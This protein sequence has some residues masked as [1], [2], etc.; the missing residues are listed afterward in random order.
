MKIF[1]NFPFLKKFQK[2]DY[3]FYLFW[4]LGL[5]SVL[6]LWGV[7]YWFLEYKIDLFDNVHLG[8][9]SYD[10][11]LGPLFIG[12]LTSLKN[13]AWVGSIFFLVNTL[14][15]MVISHFDKFY[16]MLFVVFTFVIGV[17][18]NLALSL[19]IWSNLN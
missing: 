4:F 17:L 10:V 14:I 19:L 8:I 18:L 15:L 12:P 9:L 7:Y 11:M 16:K 5:L 13:I 3:V 6:S 1:S 2:R